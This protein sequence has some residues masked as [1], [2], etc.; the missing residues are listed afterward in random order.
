MKLS[1]VACIVVGGLIGVA[2][3]VAWNITHLPHRSAVVAPST[4]A[5][6]E[7]D[8][9]LPASSRNTATPAPATPTP[10]PFVPRPKPSPEALADMDNV[11]FMLRDFRTRMGGNPTGTNAEIMKGVMGGNPVNA[12]LG[13]PEGQKLNDQGELVDRWGTPYFFHQLSKTEMEIRSAGPDHTLWT[14]D[15]IVVK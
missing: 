1:P 14:T 11:Q 7:V 6:P 12:V 8:S 5:G 4:P 15:D 13:P 9:S 10:I 2:G 3:M